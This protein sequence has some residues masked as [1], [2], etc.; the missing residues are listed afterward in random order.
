MC[1]L[2][3]IDIFHF[4]N[5][6][7]FIETVL[8]DICYINPMILLLFN[9]SSYFW[10]FLIGVRMISKHLLVVLSILSWNNQLWKCDIPGLKIQ[11]E[12]Y[13]RQIWLAQCSLPFF[14]NVTLCRFS[15]KFTSIAQILILF[16]SANVFLLIS[17]WRP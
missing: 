1:L 16:F 4:Y 13:N 8:K 9:N 10:K 14:T 12:K 6:T 3:K 17:S 5:L 2:F 7:Y 11:L 15:Q